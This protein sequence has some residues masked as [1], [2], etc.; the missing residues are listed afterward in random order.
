MFNTSE[1]MGVVK[2]IYNNLSFKYARANGVLKVIRKV[3]NVEHEQ[4]NDGA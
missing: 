1:L 2:L 4:I 3:L